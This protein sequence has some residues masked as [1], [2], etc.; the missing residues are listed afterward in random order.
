VEGSFRY[1]AESLGMD[2]YLSFSVASPFDYKNQME[3]LAPE[4][5]VDPGESF[6]NKM[7]MTVHLLKSTGGRALIL[8]RT[9]EELLEFKQEIGR[10]PECEPMTFWF[11]G[12]RELSYLTASFQREE[13]SV[14]CSVSLWEGLDVPGPSLSSVIIWSLPFP[15]MDPIYTAKRKEAAHPYEEVD[16]PYML[17]RLR[18]GMGRLIRTRSDSGMV[19]ILGEELH[20]E[21]RVRALVEAALPEG[22][23][24]KGTIEG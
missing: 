2:R 23:G 13:E 3:V 12:D 15:P 10:Y 8:F 4:L 5:G 21:E 7:Q 19:T 1:V 6:T 18:Q 17:L 14:L 20:R 16:L 24:L 22:I 11:E 9:K